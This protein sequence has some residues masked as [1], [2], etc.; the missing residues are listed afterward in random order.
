MKPTLYSYAQMIAAK[1]YPLVDLPATVSINTS[2]WVP[3]IS[4]LFH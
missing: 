2:V 4:T 3:F 1:I